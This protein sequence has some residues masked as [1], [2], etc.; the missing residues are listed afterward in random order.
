[1]QWKARF[2]YL[3]LSSSHKEAKLLKSGMVMDLGVLQKV[4]LQTG[5]LKY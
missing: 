3:H 5:C 4:M 2:Q 1:M